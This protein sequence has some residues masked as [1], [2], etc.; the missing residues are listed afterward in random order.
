M[1]KKLILIAALVGASIGVARADTF[2]P[3]N[4]STSGTLQ[5]GTVGY[6]AH[7]ASG[8]IRIFT[9][10][11]VTI[12]NSLTMGAVS[13]ATFTGAFNATGS[14]ITFG[15]SGSTI[16]VNGIIRIINNPL[17]LNNNKIV[18]VATATAG[19]DVPR[20]GQLVFVQA[21][22]TNTTSNTTNNT[23]TYANTALCGSIVT[24]GTGSEIWLVS[25]IPTFSNNPANAQLRYTRNGTVMGNEHLGTYAN[26]GSLV[27]GN[28]N[29]LLG[30]DT[31][32]SVAAGTTVSYCVQIKSSA[33]GSNVGTCDGSLACEKFMWMLEV[34]TVR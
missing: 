30:R 5:A 9:S 4:M 7:I 16:A 25:E 15:T 21:V 8:T 27:L 6:A 2:K 19:G 34:N 29:T 28:G 22:S 26:L 31:T 24:K 23:V 14:S 3:V 10:T 12:T 11:S 13:T 32:A 17:D 1:L 18:N 20:Y 33:G